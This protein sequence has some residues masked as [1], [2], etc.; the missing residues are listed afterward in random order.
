M[1]ELRKANAG[2][3]TLDAT[4]PLLKGKTQCG[5]SSSTSGMF[6][7]KPAPDASEPSVPNGLSKTLDFS[8]KVSA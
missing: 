1:H 2:V 4:S 5:D 7:S 6:T 3:F 8:R